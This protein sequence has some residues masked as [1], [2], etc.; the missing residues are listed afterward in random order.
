MKCRQTSRLEIAFLELYGH[1]RVE[2]TNRNHE[3]PLVQIDAK[4]IVQDLRY[5]AELIGIVLQLERAILRLE[6]NNWPTPKAPE[7]Q[8]SISSIVAVL[9]M[10]IARES[11]LLPRPHSVSKFLDGPFRAC[12]IVP[13]R[14]HAGTPAS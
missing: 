8:E 7:Y 3:P 14:S 5:P 1:D 2:G 13:R 9:A 10:P 4:P 6:I 11:T 12:M